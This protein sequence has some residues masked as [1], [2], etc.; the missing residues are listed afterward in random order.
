MT[1][2]WIRCKLSSKKESKLLR[3]L[4]ESGFV[5]MPYGIKH[6][7]EYD[8]YIYVKNPPEKEKSVKKSPSAYYTVARLYLDGEI[9]LLNIRDVSLRKYRNKLRELCR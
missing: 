2:N 3:S 6:I 9:I 1:N 4:K 7:W 5:M 8:G